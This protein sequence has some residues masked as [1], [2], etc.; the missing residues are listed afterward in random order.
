VNRQAKVYF[1]S[2]LHLGHANSIVFD[3][4]PFKDLDHMHRVL[5]NNYQ[6][7]VAPQSVCYFLG[8]IGYKPAVAEV[9]P[10]M[11]NGTKVLIRGNHDKNMSDNFL[12]Y[13]GFDVIL[14]RA[15]LTFHKTRIDLS[16][17]PLRG[18]FRE[19]VTGMRGAKPGENWH[20]ETRHDRYSFPDEGQY[21]LHGH[22][23][24]GPHNKKKRIDG[25]QFDV[26]VA[27]NGYK[28]VSISQVN[29]WIF[30]HKAS[31]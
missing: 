5:I 15:S 26:G 9:I 20:G 16:H 29:S 7:I 17:C 11:T 18:V 6:S 13:C 25:R 27:A 22:I 2:D 3:K 1:W 24:S 4:R 21:L 12:Y 28:P 14:D 23:H 10:K 31:K 19:D 8:D 30:K